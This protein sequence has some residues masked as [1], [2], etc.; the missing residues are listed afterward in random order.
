[1]ME[2]HWLNVAANRLHHAELNRYNGSFAFYC[3]ST[4]TLL[5]I[6]Y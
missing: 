3:M 4:I 2:M 1:M 6:D 5:R